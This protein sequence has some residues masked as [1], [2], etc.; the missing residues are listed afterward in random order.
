MFSKKILIESRI[1]DFEKTF[2][3]K[4]SQDQKEKILDEIPSKFYQWA[5]KNLDQ[6]SFDGNFELVKNLLSYFNRFGSNLKKTD[7]NQYTGVEELKI[8]SWNN[9]LNIL[10][11]GIYGSIF[12]D[13]LISYSFTLLSP[14]TVSFFFTLSVPVSYIWDVYKNNIEFNLFYLFGCLLIIISV[15]II[16]IESYKK[17]LSKV[18]KAM[19][20]NY[21]I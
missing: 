1:T 9:M 20:G 10:F 18:K 5:G 12:V 21:N 4:F 14:Q 17:Y 2:D 8:P 19:Q 7:I 6:I 3:R 13:L 15:G 11:N 16:S